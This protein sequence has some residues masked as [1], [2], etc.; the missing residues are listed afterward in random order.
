MGEPEQEDVATAPGSVTVP[1]L[2]GLAIGVCAISTA[3][4]FI[5][6]AQSSVTSL[7]LAAWR[8]T[9]ASLFLA[10]FALTAC[11]AE[12]RRLRARGWWLLVASGTVLAIHFYAWIQSLAMTSVAASIVLVSTNPFFVGLISRFV[13]RQRLRPR[14]VTG[15]VIAVVGSTII[16]LGDWGE[17]GHRVAGDLLALVGAASVA[18]YLII[19]QRLR[20]QLS[21]LGYI[22]PVYGTAAIVLMVAALLVGVPMTGYPGAAWLWLGLIALIPQIIGHS[23]FNWALGHLP[24]TYVSLA[25][26]AEPI[27][28]TVLA[29]IVLSEPPN[30]ATIAGGV[31]I[32]IGLGVATQ[33]DKT[34]RR[35]RT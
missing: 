20:A 26:L 24:A 6:L 4:T 16:G 22:F 12:W 3:S 19:G 2:V 21:L 32:L 34:T 25:A 28:S 15:M 31:L 17:G 7:A 10:P 8:L 29:W 1:P 18:V 13:L 14:T 35:V 5:R 9:L 33:R 30:V 27:G 23:S 11:R